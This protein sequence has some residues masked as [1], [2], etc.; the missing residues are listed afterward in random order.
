MSYTHAC[1]LLQLAAWRLP[2]LMRHASSSLLGH[3]LKELLRF[4]S[5]AALPIMQLAQRGAGVP[6]G[7]V[8][9]Q[10]PQPWA[11]IMVSYLQALMMSSKGER[12]AACK[13]FRS[14]EG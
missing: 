12:L 7:D 3:R 9:R 5:D 14:E 2:K 4:D 10:L 8:G 1:S 13:G 11:D 6:A